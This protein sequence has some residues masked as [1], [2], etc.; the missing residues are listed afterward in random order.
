MELGYV[1]G[2]LDGEGSIMLLKQG[3]RRSRRPVVSIGMTDREPLEAIKSEVG[4]FIRT[5]R[6]D[7]PTRKDMHVWQVNGRAALDLLA[8]VR[9]HLVMTRRQALADIVLDIPRNAHDKIAANE[10]RFREMRRR[11]KQRLRE[12]PRFA[13][14]DPGIPERAY[15]GGILDGEGHIT[16]RLRIEV[17][18]TDPELPAWLAAGFGGGVYSYR[19]RGARRPIWRWSRSPTDMDWAAG[20][21]EHM[22][23]PRKRQL[24]EKAIGFSRTPP[25]P[26][27]LDEVAVEAYKE[28]RSQ[29]VLAFVAARE[30]GLPYARVKGL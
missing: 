7:D 2:L 18:S 14:F 28:L 1:A 25:A 30:V 11:N 3:P 10:Q 26:R 22:C 8:A 13:A 29:G 27:P 20:V 17:P 19:A 4:G 12:A 21:A 6:H 5:T 23:I 24:L 16:S 9:P 15:L